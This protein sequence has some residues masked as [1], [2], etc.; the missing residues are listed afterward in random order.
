[1]T[2]EIYLYAEGGVSTEEV[3]SKWIACFEEPNMEPYSTPDE[4]YFSAVV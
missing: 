3:G 2:T 1:M 4:F